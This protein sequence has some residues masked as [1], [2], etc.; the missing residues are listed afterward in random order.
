MKKQIQHVPFVAV[1]AFFILD[2]AGQWRKTH[3]DLSAILSL[4]GFVP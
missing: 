2:L 1:S 4:R 3:S